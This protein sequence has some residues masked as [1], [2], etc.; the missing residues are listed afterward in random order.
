MNTREVVELEL[1][2]QRVL[3]ASVGTRPGEETWILKE[4]CWVVELGIGGQQVVVL[5]L[6]TIGRREA[7]ERPLATI[8]GPK[9]CGPSAAA[10]SGHAERKRHGTKQ[11]L[12][13]CPQRPVGGT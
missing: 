3:V 13:V 10:G 11:V 2:G 6:A 12:P 9:T 5:R 7:E 8:A 1:G 4:A